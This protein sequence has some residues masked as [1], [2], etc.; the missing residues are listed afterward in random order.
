MSS[1][2]MHTASWAV[3]VPGY[4]LE[5]AERVHLGVQRDTVL[6]KLSGD[7]VSWRA[8]SVSP[9]LARG[10][11]RRHG[12]ERLGKVAPIVVREGRLAELLVKRAELCTCGARHMCE[13]V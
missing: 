12:D 7:V 9:R 13:Y 4:R 10:A 8:V 5:R 1:T 11:V 2:H 6:G 3:W